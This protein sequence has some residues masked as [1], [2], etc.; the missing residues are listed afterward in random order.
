MAA[1]NVIGGI[2]TAIRPT[3]AIPATDAEIT[4]EV[5]V[6]AVAAMVVEATVMAAEDATAA[7]VSR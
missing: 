3:A 1:D 2:F 7:A 5:G 6:A 4:S